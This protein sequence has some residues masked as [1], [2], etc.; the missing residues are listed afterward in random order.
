MR[1]RIRSISRRQVLKGAAATG[2]AAA[3]S[4]SLFTPALAVPATVKI[5]LV[6]PRSGPLAL[7]YQ[8]M[9]YCIEHAKKTMHNQ[10]VIN[11]TTHPLEIVAKD[12][13]SNPNRASEVTQAY[14]HRLRD[15]G[16]RQPGF[17]SVRNQ[18]HALRHQRRPARI[19][20]LRAQG[21][22]EEGLR[23]DL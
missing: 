8:E 16:N 10:I 11:G 21:R 5:G 14:R 4:T 13:Q 9:S 20:F 6:G 3:A 7:F 2:V 19:L 1:D 17:R 12:S 15:A 18:R 22:P 23:M